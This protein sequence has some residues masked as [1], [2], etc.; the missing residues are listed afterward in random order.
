MG[1]FQ[2]FKKPVRELDE[3]YVRFVHEWPCAVSDCYPCYPVHAHHVKTRGAG[4][5]DKTCIPL[6]PLHHQM[7]HTIGIKT[8]EKKFELNLEGLIEHYNALYNDKKSGPYSHR[9]I[10]KACR[11]S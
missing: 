11:A 7:V 4:G 3:Q 10:G 2:S 1:E 5:S 6:C 8:F 9:V